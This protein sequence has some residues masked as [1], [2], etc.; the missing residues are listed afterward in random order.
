[1]V[2][3]STVEAVAVELPLVM[4]WKV[5]ALSLVLVAVA[6]VEVTEAHNTVVLVEHGTLT[7]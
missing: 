6:P 7:L 5:V 2:M 3:P 4:L 1:M